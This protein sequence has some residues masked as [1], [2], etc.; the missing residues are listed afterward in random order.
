MQEPEAENVLEREA[1]EAAIE[2]LTAQI[3]EHTAE[4]RAR[5]QHWIALEK[6]RV[7]YDEVSLL[8]LMWASS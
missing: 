3:Q 7:A 6:A 5:T 4:I 2:K 8:E 1:L